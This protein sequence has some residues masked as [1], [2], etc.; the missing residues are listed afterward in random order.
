MRVLSHQTDQGIRLFIHSFGINNP[1]KAAL[2]CLVLFAIQACNVS[3]ETTPK[4]SLNIPIMFLKKTVPNATTTI[5]PFEITSSSEAR[6]K[7]QL[8]VPL[9]DI[10]VALIDPSGQIV[11]D[12]NDKRTLIQSH[13]LLKKPEMGDLVL[14]PELR[15]P[16]MGQWSLNITHLAASGKEKINV[17]LSLLERFSLNLKLNA[18]QKSIVAG[19]PIILNMSAF[20][21]GNPIDALSPKIRIM[22]NGEPLGPG[23][24]IIDYSSASPTPTLPELPGY[25]QF[26]Y[27]PEAPGKYQFMTEIMFSGKEGPIKKS[28]SISVLVEQEQVSL[29]HIDVTRTYKSNGCVNEID[30]IVT[31]AINEPGLYTVTAYFVGENGHEIKL[32]RTRDITSIG[33]STFKI[34]LNSK[35]SKKKSSDSRIDRI[36][37]IEVLYTGLSEF[38]LVGRYPPHD[39]QPPIQ[40][41]EFCR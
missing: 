41:S 32:E 11:V 9:E 26:I 35:A 16:M 39:L 13:K 40:K 34:P 33:L 23:L 20:D 25:Y 29:K 14:L 3:G 1:I 24:S 28:D 21:Y 8:R 36:E 31:I 38:A 5:I 30:F 2:I 27:K 18:P 10:K 15:N 19:Q 22:R 4:A 6:L 7:I 17:V 37:R 12:F